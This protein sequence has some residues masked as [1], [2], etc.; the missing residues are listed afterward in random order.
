MYDLKIC[1]IGINNLLSIFRRTICA[2]LRKS[3]T[4]SLRDNSRA[5][6]TAD[7]ELT[8]RRFRG[9]YIAGYLA[10]GDGIISRGTCCL[11]IRRSTCLRGGILQGFRFGSTIFRDDASSVRVWRATKYYHAC[12]RR[13][14]RRRR[15]LIISRLLSYPP[16]ERSAFRLSTDDYHCVFRAE[17]FQIKCRRTWALGLTMPTKM[18]WRVKGKRRPD[19]FHCRTVFHLEPSSHLVCGRE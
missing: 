19:I 4:V 5:Y 10:N 7:G 11:V 6:V 2:P 3:L 14:L 12:S 8:A 17:A 13:Q 16:R 15:S 1:D 18:S 9:H